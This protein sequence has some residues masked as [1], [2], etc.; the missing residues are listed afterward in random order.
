[1]YAESGNPKVTGQLHKPIP[2]KQGDP[3]WKDS[4]LH[5]EWQGETGAK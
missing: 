5:E 4:R 1:M 3:Q 2:Q